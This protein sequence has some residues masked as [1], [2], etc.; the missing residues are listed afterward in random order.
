MG[1]F[2]NDA[3]VVAKVAVAEVKRRLGLLNDLV[4]SLRVVSV[5]PKFTGVRYD[6]G[7]IIGMNPADADVERKVGGAL[8]LHVERVTA[9]NLGTTSTTNAAGERRR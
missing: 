3:I 9:T 5:V 4:T 6:V 7:I 1:R 8:R 2:I